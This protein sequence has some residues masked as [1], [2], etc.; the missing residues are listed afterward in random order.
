MSH[1]LTEPALQPE[2]SREALALKASLVMGAQWPAR[3]ATYST[4]S[5]SLALE[6]E[7][8]LSPIAASS[9]S[10]TVHKW[11]VPSLPPL[12]TSQ[13]IRLWLVKCQS[14]ISR[15]CT[16]YGHLQSNL[17]FVFPKTV[18]QSTPKIYPRVLAHC[19]Q[20]LFIKYLARS[21]FPSVDF[22]E[23]H[24]TQL[25]WCSSKRRTRKRMES[26]V[27]VSSW[28]TP[29]SSSRTKCRLSGPQKMDRAYVQK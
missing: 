17:V 5:L 25:V 13:S 27:M 14:L 1:I 28:N 24:W 19:G 20:P 8:A 29:V 2:A 12:E 18:I 22:R 21:I 11:I 7:G 23:C 15:D 16:L 10:F 3:E 26:T 9:V 4:S 6:E